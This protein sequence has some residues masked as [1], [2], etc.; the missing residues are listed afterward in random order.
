MFDLDAISGTDEEEESPARPVQTP[1][2]RTIKPAAK[3]K[4]TMKAHHE[5]AHRYGVNAAKKL[6]SIPLEPEGEYLDLNVVSGSSGE[7]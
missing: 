5:L 4:A 6:Q 3:P 7:E 2:K 1:N